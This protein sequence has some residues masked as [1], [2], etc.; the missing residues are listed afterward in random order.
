MKHDGK[1]D[2]KQDGNRAT[3]L[4]CGMKANTAVFDLSTIA[5]GCP[6]PP[7]PP[8][9]ERVGVLAATC[10][11]F[12]PCGYES[13]REN[14]RRFVHEF[15]WW[16]VPLFVCEV[17]FEDEPDI[18]KRPPDGVTV[19]RF[20]GDDGNR[21]WQKE[22]LINYVAEILPP[23]FDSLAWID[24]DVTLFNRRWADDT[25]AALRRFDVVQ[26]WNKWH[27]LGPQG[28]INQTG[29]SVG[30]WASRFLTAASPG[31]NQAH[32]GGAWAAR[33]E[34]F[35]IYAPHALG[36]GDQFT[37]EGWLGLRD[38]FMQR[39][40]N[41]EWMESLLQWA[42]VAEDKVQG[43]V[44][45]IPGEM[46]HH[47]HGTRANRGYVTRHAT[48]AQYGFNPTKH[49]TIDPQGLY[50]WADAAPSGLRLAVREYFTSRKE[51]DGNSF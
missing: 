11:Y 51:D 36:G 39:Q 1:H 14:Y 34:V 46:C 33:R 13:L 8:E 19:L 50:A 29:N 44:T 28:D 10:N 23:E 35:P 15:A 12:N 6:L 21:L 25:L 27:F 45:S 3:C 26:L 40:L 18:I 43:R 20:R 49:L 7:D 4:R 16:G 24:A 37:L 17:L 5:E 38:T 47:Y 41:P 9:V 2:W 22:R 48:L 42:T 32:P 31:S 30:R